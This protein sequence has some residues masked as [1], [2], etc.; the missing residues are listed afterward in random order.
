MA[1]P[2][3]L[4]HVGASCAAS[5]PRVEDSPERASCRAGDAV[6]VEA[7]DDLA[8]RVAASYV[9]VE[10]SPHDGSFW[11][12]DLVAGRAGVAASHAAGIRRGPW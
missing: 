12:V 5:A 3:G 4:A 6:G 10:D 2:V 9:V 11:L 8:D 7:F 1:I